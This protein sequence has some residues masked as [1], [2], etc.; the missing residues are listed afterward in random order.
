MSPA[1]LMTYISGQMLRTL[2]LPEPARFTRLDPAP[3]PV[4]AT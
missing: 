1:S 4:S 3:A 2:A